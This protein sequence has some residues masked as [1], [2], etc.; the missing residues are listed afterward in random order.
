MDKMLGAK[1]DS[2]I[3]LEKMEID[4]IVVTNGEKKSMSHR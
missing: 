1:E 4:V 3:E 2:G